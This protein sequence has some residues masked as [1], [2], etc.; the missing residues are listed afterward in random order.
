[1]FFDIFSALCAE[2]G[3]TKNRAAIEI[4]LSNSTVTKWKKTNATPDSA[5]LAKIGK[6]F[7]VG[8]D[9]LLGITPDSYLMVTRY[10][11][12]EAKKNYAKAT[13]EKTRDELAYA[14]DILTESLDDQLLA[15]Q[16]MGAQKAHESENTE[17]LQ[18]LRDEEK[19][20]LAVT[21]GM[22]AE[23]IRQMTAFASLMK[24]NNN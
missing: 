3:I 12:A 17:L 6:Y 13:D 7:G 4:G 19:A 5:T 24:G 16:L 14:I 9:F 20:L 10:Q 15:M 22:T 1:M 23:Q 21:K 2:R 11:L 18:N 8:T